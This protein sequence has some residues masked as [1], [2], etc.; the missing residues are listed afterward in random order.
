[1]KV[2]DPVTETS[3]AFSHSFRGQVQYVGAFVDPTTRTTPVRIVTQNPGG[4]L[5]KDLFVEADI[6]TGARKNILVV[7]VSAVLHDAQNEPM[8]YIAT[9]TNEFAQ[10]LVTVGVQQG[11]DV[12]ITSGIKPGES[13][14]AQGSLF[15]QFALTAK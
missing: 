4:V 5:K 3:P 1:V 8:V 11:N 12:E 2:G 9:K 15:V 10:R 13:V 7:P 6:L 14:V